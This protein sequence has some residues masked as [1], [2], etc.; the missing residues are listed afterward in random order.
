MDVCDAVVELEEAVV[1]VTVWDTAGAD[2]YDQLRRLSFPDTDVFLVCFC[3]VTRSSFVNAREKW[4]A[5]ATVHGASP[6]AKVVLVGTKIDLRDDLSSI[7][8]LE[9]KNVAPISREEGVGLAKELGMA[10]YAETSALTGDGVQA[11]FRACCAIFL[12]RQDPKP[13][14]GV[15]RCVLQ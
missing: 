8:R 5:E 11:L 9:K 13:M 6:N 14:V 4:F 1:T 3:V 7:D 12:Q 10:A 2:Q 15:R